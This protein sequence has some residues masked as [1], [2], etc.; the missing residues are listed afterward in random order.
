MGV[1]T[2][3]EYKPIR[4]KLL[5]ETG[6]PFQVTPKFKQVSCGEFHTG[7]LAGNSYLD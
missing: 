1:E 7:F 3:K 6:K 2:I 4:V 5:D